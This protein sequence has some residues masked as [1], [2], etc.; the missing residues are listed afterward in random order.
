[1]N[2]ATAEEL[3]I[4]IDGCNPSNWDAP[5]IFDN[6]LKGK[7]TASNATI[8]IWEGF[9]TT[10]DIFATWMKRFRQEADRVIQ[11][12]T[13]EDILE[14]KNTGKTGIILGWQNLSPIEDDLER[15]EI[16]H[17]LGL[18]V[19]QLTYNL[20][21]LVGNGCYERKDDGLSRFGIET[22]K[23]MN[24][25][26]IL[27]DLS[28]VGDQTSLETIEFS[29]QPVAFTHANLR[30]FHPEARNKPKALVQAL[31][32]KGGVIGA[33]AFPRFLPG[34]YDSTIEHYL[35]AIESL[36]EV[37][38]IDH[39]ALASDFCESRDMKFWHWLRA[40]HGKFPGEAPGVPRPD[41][42]IRGLETT[43]EMPNVVSGLASRGYSQEEVS[44]VVGG[45]WIRIYSEVWKGK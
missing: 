2:T 44:K 30:E 23:K 18:R 32:E 43:A 19:A 22:I 12:K 40:L 15:L 20:R 1:M 34:G 41:P 7:V 24:E 4:I 3:P 38:G 33:N 29:E 14:A 17:A 35:D 27:I 26:G 42:S 13:V 5:D 11:V 10:A 8:A 31:V 16:F 37:A 36:I 9:E 21:N 45:N 6:L 25:L 28:H 39:V